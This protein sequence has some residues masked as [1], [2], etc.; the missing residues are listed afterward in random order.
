MNVS[1]SDAQ[2]SNTTGFEDL[3]DTGAVNCVNIPQRKASEFS[4]WPSTAPAC[5]GT[6]TAGNA[7][8]AVGAAVAAGAAVGASLLQLERIRDAHEATPTRTL[9]LSI[10]IFCSTVTL[11]AKES[12][13]SKA[14]TV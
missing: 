14:A 9:R 3:G 8:A 12:D 13:L 4:V 7:A 6:A 11:L 1:A 2:V 5:A 10:D